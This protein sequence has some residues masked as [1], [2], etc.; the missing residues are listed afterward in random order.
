MDTGHY[1][2]TLSFVETRKLQI[3]LRHAEKLVQIEDR[4]NRRR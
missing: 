4:K 3:R 1:A 2:T